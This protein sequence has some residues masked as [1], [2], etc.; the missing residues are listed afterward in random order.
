MDHIVY[1]IFNKKKNLYLNKILTVTLGDKHRHICVSL[2]IHSCLF[3]DGNITSKQI[4]G[5]FLARNQ[6]LKRTQRIQ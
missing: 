3:I 5:F 1:I 4:N 6:H 2:L